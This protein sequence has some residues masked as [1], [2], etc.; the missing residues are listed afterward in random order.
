MEHQFN[1]ALPSSLMNLPK[2]TLL[3]CKQL[4]VLS[5]QVSLHVMITYKSYTIRRI[6][7]QTWFSSTLNGINSVAIRLG[8]RRV[9]SSDH[10]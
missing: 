10:A 3:Q 4:T 9:I 5:C 1:G 8:F 6:P 2:V 7:L